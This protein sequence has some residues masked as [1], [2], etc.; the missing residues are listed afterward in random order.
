M[1]LINELGGWTRVPERELRK[2]DLQVKAFHKAI[3]ATRNPTLETASNSLKESL[4]TKIQ[5]LEFGMNLVSERIY[6]ESSRGISIHIL[7]SLV[8]SMEMYSE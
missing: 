2:E 1:W 3:V 6:G 8:I 4:V 5:C 7:D